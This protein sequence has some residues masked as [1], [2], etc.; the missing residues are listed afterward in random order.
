MVDFSGRVRSRAW[1]QHHAWLRVRAPPS[2]FAQRLVSRFD[3]VSG[4]EGRETVCVTL[5]EFTVPCNARGDNR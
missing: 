1:L 3:M 4:T 5:R 2:A